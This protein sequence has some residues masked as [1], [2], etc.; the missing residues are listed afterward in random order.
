MTWYKQKDRLW[1]IDCRRPRYPG[2]DDGLPITP[3]P[4]AATVVDPAVAAFWGICAERHTAGNSLELGRHPLGS[5]LPHSSWYNT[6]TQGSP[7]PPS[8][9]FVPSV[10]PLGIPWNWVAI[11]L[12]HRC[13]IPPGITPGPKDRLRRCPSWNPLDFGRLSARIDAAP[14]VWYNTRPPGFHLPHYFVRK[15]YSYHPV[16]C[17]CLAK[18][19]FIPTGI[20]F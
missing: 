16:C 15:I 1:L 13:P 7:S 12:D 4:P 5:L 3:P 6:R 20:V 11:R 9:E 18:N 2:I 14:L 8:E 10:A 17:V 19:S